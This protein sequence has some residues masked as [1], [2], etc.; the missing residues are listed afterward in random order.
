MFK[1]FKRTSIQRLKENA[2]KLG[3]N[4]V[5]ALQIDVEPFANSSTILVSILGTAVKVS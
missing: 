5:V 2:S 3:T 1:K 4:A